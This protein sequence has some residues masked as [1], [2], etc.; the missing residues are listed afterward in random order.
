MRIQL[1]RRLLH[2]EADF[3]PP[4]E[5]PRLCAPRYIPILA[6]W[7]RLAGHSA[8]ESSAT[9]FDKRLPPHSDSGLYLVT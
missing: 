4:Q 3:V 7:R 1:R 5:T 9:R 6:F 2:A 8:A